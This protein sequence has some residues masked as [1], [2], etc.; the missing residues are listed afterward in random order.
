MSYSIGLLTL[1]IQLVSMS[2]HLRS[3]SMRRPG[4]FVVTRG[5]FV[6][7]VWDELAAKMKDK[8][9]DDD[10]VKTVSALRSSLLSRVLVSKERR[11]EKEK[12]EREGKNEE[13]ERERDQQ[14]D[15]MKRIR[16]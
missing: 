4:Y 8:T 10:E 16:Q 6:A 11:K 7:C 13:R 5:H 3:L 14:E 2:G 15:I 1:T 9:A 12:K